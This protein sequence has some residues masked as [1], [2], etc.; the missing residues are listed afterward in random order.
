MNKAYIIFPLIAL[1]IFGG[2]YVS[3]SKGY[4][5]KVAEAKAKVEQAKKDKLAQQV[6]DRETALA[7]ATKA[8]IDRKKER[9]E[10][11]R[12]EEAKKVARQ[13]AEDRRM[14][15]HD[16]LLKFRDQNTRLKKDLDEVKEVIGKVSEEKKRHADEEAFLKTYV[17]QAEANVK[18]YTDL[19]DK[20]TAAEKAAAE[21]AAAAAALAKQKG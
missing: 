12:V 9:E 10:R 5:A 7:A 2:F 11:D 14:R 16:D 19:L 17:K 20:V 4:E 15:A 13:E 6:K 8:A 21:A 3:F 1:L 18:Y